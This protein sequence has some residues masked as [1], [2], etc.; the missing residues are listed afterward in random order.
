[1]RQFMKAS[2]LFQI[3]ILLVFGI[4]GKTYGIVPNDPIF[5]DQ[6]YLHNT[7]QDGGVVGADIHAT[8]AW[9]ITTGSRSTITSKWEIPV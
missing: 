4:A 7:G 8:E 3:I 9:D 2:Q 1:M 6:W 5:P